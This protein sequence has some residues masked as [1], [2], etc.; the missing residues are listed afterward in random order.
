MS[1]F[2]VLLAGET[3]HAT[4]RALRNAH[5]RCRSGRPGRRPHSRHPIADTIGDATRFRSLMGSQGQN[6]GETPATPPSRRRRRSTR[7]F[8]PF[9]QQGE[10]AELRPAQEERSAGRDRAARP[11]TRP[12]GSPDSTSTS[13]APPARTPARDPALPRRAF[14]PPA[15]RS[16]RPKRLSQTMSPQPRPDGPSSRWRSACDRS[17]ASSF[18][19][20]SPPP[21]G[22]RHASRS[23]TKKRRGPCYQPK[24]TAFVMR[25]MEAWTRFVETRRAGRRRHPPRSFRR[26]LPSETLSATQP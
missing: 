25:S 20:R 1:G 26:P 11:S 3:N 15:A 13:I 10:F 4:A 16:S 19:W 5:R 24:A 14:E 6:K 7:I 2:S 12:V 21:A 18:S 17:A 8:G 22:R 23:R 9:L